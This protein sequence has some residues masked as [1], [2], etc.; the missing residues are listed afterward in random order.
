MESYE[1][2]ECELT[3]IFSLFVF[4]FILRRLF[5]GKLD[6]KDPNASIDFDGQLSLS[7]E[8]PVYQFT[9]PQTSI[10]TERRKLPI[11]WFLN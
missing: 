7:E 10:V 5:V 4:I 3:N 6:L 9:I 8:K 11:L 1:I 2:A